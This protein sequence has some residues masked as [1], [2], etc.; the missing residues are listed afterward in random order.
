MSQQHV[1]KGASAHRELGCAGILRESMARLRVLAEGGQIN[2][3]GGAISPD[4]LVRL[5][6][7]ARLL[8]E[9]NGITPPAPDGNVRV[10]GVFSNIPDLPMEAQ[11]MLYFLETMA[12]RPAELGV[13]MD[14]C[15]V[16]DLIGQQITDLVKLHLPILPEK[17]EILSPRSA[18]SR[19]RAGRGVGQTRSRIGTSASD[20][21]IRPPGL[22]QSGRW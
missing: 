12:E 16:L 21:A 9:N 11:L 20:R 4:E 5:M 18:G 13:R 22:E 6:A 1:T 19:I 8:L 3:D 17:G 2:Q 14:Q 15:P 10:E 7:E